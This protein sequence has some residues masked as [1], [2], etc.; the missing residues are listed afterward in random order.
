M[1]YP[2]LDA[3]RKPSCRLPRSILYI[4]RRLELL[5]VPYKVV[6]RLL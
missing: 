3:L 5:I 1:S 6:V 2:S 4:A